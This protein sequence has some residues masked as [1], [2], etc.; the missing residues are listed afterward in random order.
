[1]EI[2][3]KS[4]QLIT[5]AGYE[6]IAASTL[7]TAAFT[8]PMCSER[9]PQR[10]VRHRCVQN[11]RHSNLHNINEPITLPSSRYSLGSLLVGFVIS[12]VFFETRFG[13][14][15]GRVCIGFV[16]LIAR[17]MRDGCFFVSAASNVVLIE[18]SGGKIEK[19]LN[20]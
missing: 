13:R 14:F 10:H 6:I 8:N 15:G 16:M 1:M 3:L 18:N 4:T 11:V 7:A 5:T 20:L 12:Q 17:N 19:H 9:E 2:L